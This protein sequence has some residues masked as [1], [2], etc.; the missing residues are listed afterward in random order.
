MTKLSKLSREEAESLLNNIK[1]SDGVE[2]IVLCNAARDAKKSRTIMSGDAVLESIAAQITTE[3]KPSGQLLNTPGS[4]CIRVASPEAMSTSL[5]D[6]TIY[7]VA[8]NKLVPFIMRHHYGEC[9]RTFHIPHDATTYADLD[10]MA[11]ALEA[12]FVERCVL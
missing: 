3:L 2:F 11:D 7:M 6:T 8:S 10:T 5:I 12:A 9:R 4:V 1:S